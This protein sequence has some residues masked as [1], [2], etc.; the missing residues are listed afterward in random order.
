MFSV[1][2]WTI[3]YKMDI[4][5]FNSPNDSWCLQVFL[6]AL[7]CV[8]GNIFMGPT[9][10]LQITVKHPDVTLNSTL[11]MIYHYPIQC[12]LANITAVFIF[13]S[14]LV[15]NLLDLL[16]S[17]L[18]LW[19]SERL[20]W[21]F[22]FSSLCQCWFIMCCLIYCAAAILAF[23]IVARLIERHLRKPYVDRLTEK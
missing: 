20:Y 11:F 12:L 10:T 17:S 2:I 8:W 22:I 13:N 18:K 9:R 5:S 21:S 7:S 3:Q 6:T 16:H 15:L 14:S 1:C 4:V 19:R 23:A